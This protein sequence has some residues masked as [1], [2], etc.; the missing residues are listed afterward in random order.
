MYTDKNI[1]GFPGFRDI[2]NIIDNPGVDNNIERVH[3]NLFLIQVVSEAPR[4][5]L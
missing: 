5:H 2:D 4:S 3:I 1:D